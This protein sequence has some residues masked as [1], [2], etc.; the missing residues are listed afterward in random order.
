MGLCG[1]GVKNGVLIRRSNIHVFVSMVQIHLYSN[2]RG[3]LKNAFQPL[4]QGLVIMFYRRVP[5]LHFVLTGEYEK[6]FL[7]QL[8]WGVNRLTCTVVEPSDAAKRMRESLRKSDETKDVNFTFR[9]ER[10]EDYRRGRH[11][12]A[13]Y[14]VISSIHSLY[15]ISGEVK[16][17][18]EYILSL[19]EEGGVFIAVVHKGKRYL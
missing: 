18:I 17:S 13:K 16:S 15:C 10:L 4:S 6:E 9:Q 12:N 2:E 5:S 8:S 11:G 3:F 14:Y 1:V 7:K 19:I